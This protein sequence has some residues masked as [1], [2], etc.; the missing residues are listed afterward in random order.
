MRVWLQCGIFMTAIALVC[1]MNPDLLAR[2]PHGHR[3][4]LFR[5]SETRHK[6]TASP[7]RS[8]SEFRPQGQALRK[9]KRRAT[10]GSPPR[11][12]IQRLQRGRHD[13]G[14]ISRQRAR[15]R[16]CAEK[17]ASQRRTSDQRLQAA[18]DSHSPRDSR[19]Q[20][21]DLARSRRIQ[22]AA[23]FVEQDLSLIDDELLQ[24][25]FPSPPPQPAGSSPENPPIANNGTLPP[26]LGIAF[27]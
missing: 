19:S 6:R 15:R 9:I 11:L 27:G 23:Q 8:R 25:L 22:T 14:E 13:H 21:N 10:R 7:L 26:L 4:K 16:R 5:Q 18:P 24:S 3:G 2:F 12:A 1:C 20:R 17:R